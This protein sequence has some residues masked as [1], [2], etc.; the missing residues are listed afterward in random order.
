MEVTIQLI[1]STID[2]WTHPMTA[3]TGVVYKP[4][5]Q[6]TFGFE[7][8]SDGLFPTAPVYVLTITVRSGPFGENQTVTRRQVWNLDSID[9]DW[10][11]N[12]LFAAL[13]F[14]WSPYWFDGVKWKK[15]MEM[16]G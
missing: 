6:W 16:A 8:P 12:A 4:L 1:Q 3:Y 2:G 7:T 5:I 15:K 14:A 11:T 10:V 13:T 9:K